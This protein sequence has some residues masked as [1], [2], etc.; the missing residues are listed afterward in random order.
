[1]E[2]APVVEA[3]VDVFQKVSRR[4][5]RVGRIHG[6][7]DRAERSV[8]ANRHLAALPGRGGERRIWRNEQERCNKRQEQ[9][10]RGP[11][12]QH[13]GRAAGRTCLV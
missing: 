13:C 8:N 12:L 7:R 1:M 10:H 3:G 5:R 11:I 6:D 9:R 2:A 4:D